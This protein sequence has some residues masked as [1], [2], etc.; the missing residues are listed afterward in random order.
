MNPVHI[1]TPHSLEIHFISFL[2]SVPYSPKLFPPSTFPSKILYT[3]VI[4]PILLD[5]TILIIF[6]EGY[7]YEDPHYGIFLRHP[8]TFSL[9]IPIIFFS[10]PFSNTLILFFPYSGGPYP[11]LTY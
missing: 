10:T 2:A 6:G 9:L 5:L 3:N 8:A 7:N 1:I 4:S 11:P